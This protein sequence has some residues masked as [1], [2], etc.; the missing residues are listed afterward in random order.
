MTDILIK[1]KGGGDLETEMRPGRV[2]CDDACRGWGDVAE[3]GKSVIA[4][5]ERVLEQILS[6]SPKKEPA[7]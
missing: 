2:P 4:S 5:W 7:L 6:H 3:L 1:K